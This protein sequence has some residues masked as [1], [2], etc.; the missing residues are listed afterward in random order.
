MFHITK[1]LLAKGYVN[2]FLLKLVTPQERAEITERCTRAAAAQANDPRPPL[3]GQPGPLP[4]HEP[5]APP[6][7]SQAPTAPPGRASAR[8]DA[9]GIGR[10]PDPRV[11]HGGGYKAG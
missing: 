8:Y 2:P 1:D 10:G 11:L 5:N 6:K 7:S 4:R 9:E 3:P